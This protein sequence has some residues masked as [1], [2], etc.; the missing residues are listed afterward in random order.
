MIKWIEHF[1]LSQFLVIRLEDY[2]GNPREYMK[3]IFDFLD[4][5]EP[6]ESEWNMIT[7]NNHVN[8]NKIYRLLSFIYLLQYQHHHHHRYYYYTENL[9]DKILKSYYGMYYLYTKH[10]YKLLLLSTVTFTNL[11]IHYYHLF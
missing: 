7:F 8:E 4:L 2:D 3:T 11:T 1:S 10:P 5:S 6:D 9:F